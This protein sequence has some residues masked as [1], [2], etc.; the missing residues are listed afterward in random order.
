MGEILVDDLCVVSLLDD[1]MGILLRESID[2]GRGRTALG[3]CE[4]VGRIVL[5]DGKLLDL[6]NAVLLDNEL[7]RL[8]IVETE[9]RPD[10]DERDDE[11]EIER[12]GVRARDDEDDIEREGV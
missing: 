4:R 9:L 8:E 2:D 3:E 11:D 1:E 7:G 5:V 10:I 12:E 6:G